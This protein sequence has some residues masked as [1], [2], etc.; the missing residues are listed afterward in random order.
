MRFF[1]LE[2]P[3]RRSMM[4]TVRKGLTALAPPRV[5]TP[6]EVREHVKAS[7]AAHAAVGIPKIYHAPSRASCSYGT[8]RSVPSWNWTAK[9][10]GGP[11]PPAGLPG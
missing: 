7:L 1:V 6:E 8:G 10:A 11:E 3:A 2:S 9:I 5:S 4:G